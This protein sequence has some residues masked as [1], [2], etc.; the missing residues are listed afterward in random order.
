MLVLGAEVRGLRDQVYPFMLDSHRELAAGRFDDLIARIVELD[1]QLRE[2]A[3][4]L[5]VRSVVSRPLAEVLHREVEGFASRT[6]IEASAEVRGDPETLSGQ[7]RIALFR[8][9]QESLS[10]IREH[11]GATTATVRLHVRRATVDVRVIDNGHG[12]EVR[13]SLASAAKS[14]RLGIVGIGERM[15][16]LGGSFDVESRP[17]GPTTIRFSLPRWEPFQNINGDQ[18]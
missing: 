16:M 8:A 4:S 6:G 5:E 3:H 7:Q 14:G 10:N 12:F 2:T 15:R 1:R 9:I 11:S 17:G 18:I 13:E